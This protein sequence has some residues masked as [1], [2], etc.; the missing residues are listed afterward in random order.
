MEQNIV[1]YIG[2]FK[3]LGIIGT[4]IAS[5]AIGV[6]RASS[7]LTKVETKVDIF[8][9]RL[10]NLEGRLD[11]AFAG[12]S[13][14]AL[15]PKGQMILDDSGLKKYIDEKKDDLL[16]RCKSRNM[17]MN[18]YDIQDSAFKF[19]DQLNFGDFETTLKSSAFKHGVSMDTVRR[20]G[21]I[22]FRDLCLA[23]HDFKPEDL[24]KP[25]IS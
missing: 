3:A 17:M 23:A 18:P 2:I 11:S 15:L 19:F 25:K 13:P 7:R 21:G 24:D 5:V 6:W 1:I 9:N 10:T 16:T 8:E 12:G 4:I 22:Y 14:V 20:I